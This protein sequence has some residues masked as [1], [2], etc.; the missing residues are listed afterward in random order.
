[1]SDDSHEMSSLFSLKNNN[2]NRMSL[3]KKRPSA[4]RFRISEPRGQSEL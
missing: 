4:L 1:M 3:T 2:I